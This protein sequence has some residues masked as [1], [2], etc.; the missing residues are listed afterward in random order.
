MDDRRLLEGHHGSG[1]SARNEHGRS[2]PLA[3]R[4]PPSR[5]AM[6]LASPHYSRP[7]HRSQTVSIHVSILIYTG[8]ICLLPHRLRTRGVFSMG[9][10]VPDPCGSCSETSLRGCPETNI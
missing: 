1:S 2:A 4:S 10:C 6:L 5:G 8:T 7:S 3:S 9:G